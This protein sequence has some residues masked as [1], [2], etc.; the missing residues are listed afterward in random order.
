MQMFIGDYY[1][2]NNK[3]M[4]RTAER[5]NVLGRIGYKRG[6]NFLYTAER[7]L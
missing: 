6:I 1:R 2:L 4:I 3:E 7:V 5:D